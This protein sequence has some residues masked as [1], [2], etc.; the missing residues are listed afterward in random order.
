MPSADLILDPDSEAPIRCML[1]RDKAARAWRR[2]RPVRKTPGQQ[3]ALVEGSLVWTSWHQGDGY[4]RVAGTD[5]MLPV[6]AEGTL[7][8]REP[9][10]LRL[11]PKITEVSGPVDVQW[12][13]AHADFIWA[14]GD[15]GT[16]FKLWKITPSTATV[17]TTTTLGSSASGRIGVP[18]LF[19]GSYWI[20][21]I[22]G[23]ASAIWEVDSSAAV[24]DTQADSEDEVWE[25]AVQSGDKLYIAAGSTVRSI[26]SGVDPTD[27]A[28]WSGPFTA[29]D[30]SNDVV[31]LTTLGRVV[32]VG[33]Q[34][35]LN[36]FDTDL[37]L[38]NQIPDLAGY[39]HE[40]NARPLS[41]WHGAIV[42][43]HVR[44]IFYFVEGIV[45]P[46]GLD[47]TRV[48]TT[49]LRGRVFSLVADGEY[50]WAKIHAP[51]RSGGNLR[52]VLV[53][54]HERSDEQVPTPVIWTQLAEADKLTARPETMA[55]FATDTAASL[56]FPWDGGL[57]TIPLPDLNMGPL[58]PAAGSFELSGSKRLPIVNCDAPLVEKYAKSVEIDLDNAAIGRAATVRYALNPQSA[59][60]AFVDLGR[61]SDVGRT[62]LAF[63]TGTTFRETQ[64]D[65]ILETDDSTESPVVRRVAL[66]YLERPQKNIVHTMTLRLGDGVL[67]NEDNRLDDADVLLD[68]LYA[69]E[70]GGEAVDAILPNDRR[71]T[72]LILEVVESEAEEVED[73]R[74]VVHATVTLEEVP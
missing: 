40:A 61:A 20:P 46:I 2:Q 27:T 64:L 62:E 70:D 31:W 38:V 60:P 6:A 1:R 58:E 29:G 55:V 44:G 28:N 24:S 10:F 11:P 52:E 9:Y 7:D 53:V 65:I 15:D 8:A 74:R 4:G 57:A 45:A 34:D 21:L 73:A 33:R 13:F 3:T 72:V 19:D 48:N 67:D 49:L 37:N 16:D 25:V 51:A 18:V 30:E 5:L 59:D 39:Q 68:R 32:Y 43:P 54:G 23:A 26:A 36:A 14:V 71:A 69:L 42:V 41:V 22:D 50:L 63:P 56:W 66:N 35:G 12:V 47:R 17:S